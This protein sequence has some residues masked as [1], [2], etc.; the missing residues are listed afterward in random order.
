MT[1]C[2]LRRDRDDAA[3]RSAAKMNQRQHLTPRSP[4][5][6]LSNHSA[7]REDRPMSV[8]V[9]P[10]ASGLAIV[11]NRANRKSSVKGASPGS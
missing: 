5:H 8:R 7:L 9:K 1:S 11:L 4:N 2:P 3:K 6:L 10:I